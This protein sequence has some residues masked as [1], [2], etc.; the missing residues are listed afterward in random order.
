[1][2]THRAHAGPEYRLL[3]AP[4]FDERRQIPTTRF[5][6]ETVKSFASFRYG[7]SVNLAAAPGSIRCT[8]L[9]LQAPDL[10][11]PAA[12]HA[13]F[14][15]EF[16]NLHGLCEVTIQGLDGATATFS[17]RITPSRV[18]VVRKPPQS[19]VELITDPRLWPAD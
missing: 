12:G 4:A 5:L 8:V 14:E 18:Q 17:V 1:M 9:G 13:R 15:R 10:S 3:L 11:L 7:L 16:D 6:L 2:G 19:F